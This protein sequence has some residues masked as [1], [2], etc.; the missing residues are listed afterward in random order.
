MQRALEYGER[1]A[2]A[3][4]D[5]LTLLTRLDFVHQSIKEHDPALH[6]SLRL[7]FLQRSVEQ[8]ELELSECR[9]RLRGAV[10]EFRKRRNKLIN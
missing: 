6:S 8:L 4:A 3:S 1:V 10:T 7:Q 5:T 2:E 9:L